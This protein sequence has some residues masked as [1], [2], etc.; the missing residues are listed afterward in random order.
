MLA[1][2]HLD[3]KDALFDQMAAAGQEGFDASKKYIDEGKAE[4]LARLDPLIQDIENRQSE[5]ATWYNQR[6]GTSYQD[7]AEAQDV[8]TRAEKS[9][10][11]E[12]IYQNYTENDYNEF[13]HQVDLLLER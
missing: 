8:L 7:T 6:L 3:S 1:S 13:L 9:N 4:Q 5:L 11:D 12:I 2:R 10:Q